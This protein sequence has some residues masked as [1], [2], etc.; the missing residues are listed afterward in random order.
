VLRYYL[1][2]DNRFKQAIKIFLDKYI[3]ITKDE[4][5]LDYI[6]ISLLWVFYVNAS[7]L[8]Q[9]FLNRDEDNFKRLIDVIENFDKVKKEVFKF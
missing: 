8:V 9:Q 3:K 4:K 6:D 5:I 2:R 7:P 1:F